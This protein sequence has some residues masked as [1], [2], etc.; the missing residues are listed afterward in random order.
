M[1]LLENYTKINRIK[2]EQTAVKSVKISIRY[3]YWSRAIHSIKLYQKGSRRD[4]IHHMRKVHFIIN[5]ASGREEPVLTYIN[6]AME[7]KPIHWTISITKKTGDAFKQTKDALKKKV[8]LIAVYGGDGT[9]MEAAEAL[10]KKKTPLLPLPGGSGNVMARELRIPIDTREALKLILRRELKTKVVDMGV[11]DK[12]PFMLWINVGL[13]AKIVVNTDRSLK[14]RLGSQAYNLIGLK[15]FVNH[16][17]ISYTIEFDKRKI[18]ETGVS[19]MVANAGNIGILGYPVL[20]HIS[21]QDGMLD[22][23]LFKSITAQSLFTW[24]RSNITRKKPKGEIKHWRAKSVT[25][26]SQPQYP[27]MI[28]DMT[29]QIKKPTITIVPK[30][31]TVVVP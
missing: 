29:R 6:K 14:E 19:L 9:V 25:I 4:T 23:V 11:C 28:D 20:P 7:G 26:S 22:V 12:K 2:V 8:D 30:S 13:F 16:E 18:T 3:H 15:E 21:I 1:I 5:P 10:H 27:V 24:L 31:L 17:Q